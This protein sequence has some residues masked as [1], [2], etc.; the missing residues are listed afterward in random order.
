M[1]KWTVEIEKTNG[2]WINYFVDEGL[3]WDTCW[4]DTEEEA[5]NMFA[6]I[7]NEYDAAYEVLDYSKAINLQNGFNL[8][9]KA[10][11]TSETSDWEHI[12]KFR[13]FACEPY[14][15]CETE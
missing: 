12:Y 3:F 1:Q 15:P 11:S 4:F 9:I 13:V 5:L 7:Q 10:K 2:D 14:N 6:E 8:T